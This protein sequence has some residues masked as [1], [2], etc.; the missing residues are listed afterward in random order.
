MASKSSVSV[1]TKL[2]AHILFWVLIVVYESVVW[3]LVDDAY[4][5][6]FYS[7]LVDLPVKI[8]AAYFTLYVLIDLLLVKKKYPLFFFLLI[9]SAFVFGLI[10]RALSY[11][12]I[13][14]RFYPDALTTPLLYLP[15]ILIMM[16]SIYSVVGLLASFHLIEHWYKN[17]KTAQRL[18]QERQL[19]EKEMLAARL[20]LLTSQINPHFLYNT[21]N[22]IYVMALNKFDRTPECIHRLSELTSYMLNESNNDFVLLD[23]EINYTRNYIE[24]KR[25]RYGDNADISLN[26][27]NETAGVLIAPLLLLPF[28]EN[29]FKHGLSAHIHDGWLRVDI[30]RKDFELIIKVENSKNT[31]ANTKTGTGFGLANVRKRLDLVYGQYYKLD[32]MEDEGVHLVV[33][34]IPCIVEDSGEKQQFYEMH[35]NR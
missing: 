29:A 12:I 14:P 19:L 26:V 23:Q 5:E 8:T 25:L 17:Q 1:R 31:A 10:S 35:S 20:K 4:F 9:L 24:L 33:L 15:K 27:F 21:L 6:R 28:V 3:G 2:L 22:N 18:E 32:I 7:S 16:F 30:S 34:R 13:Y 11:N